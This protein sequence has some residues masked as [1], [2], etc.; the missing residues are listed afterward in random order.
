MK[1]KK[2]TAKDTKKNG[3]LAAVLLIKS[4]RSTY[5]SFPQIFC[6]ISGSN[7]CKAQYFQ[8][9]K[10]GRMKKGRRRKREDKKKITKQYTSEHF[11]ASL[12]R[13]KSRKLSIFKES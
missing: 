13:L 11:P 1:N 12:F 2:R 3:P 5:V 8:W 4:D 6:W 10:E 7:Y 9:I